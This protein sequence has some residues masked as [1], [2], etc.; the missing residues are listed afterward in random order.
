MEETLTISQDR[1]QAVMKGC[2]LIPLY[3]NVL[4]LFV[5][6]LVVS[7]LQAAGGYPGAG[8]PGE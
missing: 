3:I 6:L 4:F 2:L 8:G 1:K 7:S 5:G